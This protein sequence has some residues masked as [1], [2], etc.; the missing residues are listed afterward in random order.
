MVALLLAL[1]LQAT[2]PPATGLS[3]DYDAVDEIAGPVTLFMVCLDGQATASCAQVPVSAG[4]V[5]APGTKTYTWKLPALLPGAHTVAVQACT[6]G[7]AQC[8]SGSTLAITVQV[9][10]AN[11]KGLRLVK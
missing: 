3:W 10:L 7:A 6:A 4:V 5:S 2:V 9:A 11:P 1:A 8:S